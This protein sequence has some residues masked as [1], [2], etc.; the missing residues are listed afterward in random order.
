MERS[1]WPAEKFSPGPIAPPKPGEISGAEHHPWRL[2][3]RSSF[4]FD[5]QSKAH[6]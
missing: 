2:N 3:W 1:I 6:G 5:Y 4:T